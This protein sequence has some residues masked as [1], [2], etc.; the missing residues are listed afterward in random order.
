MIQVL[1]IPF[2]WIFPFPKPWFLWVLFTDSAAKVR[3]IFSY[4]SYSHRMSSTAAVTAFCAEELEKNV[5]IPCWHGLQVS[6]PLQRV[7]A[8]LLSPVPSG[9][10][11]LRVKISYLCEDWFIRCLLLHA[12][13]RILGYN[14]DKISKS[15]ILYIFWSLFQKYLKIY[16]S[17]EIK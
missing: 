17:N 3:W 16:Y 2:L 6:F 5:F 10:C 13:N 8:Q 12:R 4:Q 15:F 7:L 14:H 9:S 11:V 1:G